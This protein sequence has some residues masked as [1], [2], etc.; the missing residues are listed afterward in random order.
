MLIN[1]SEL[2]RQFETENYT[3]SQ[4]NGLIL[5]GECPHTLGVKEKLM[6]SKQTHQNRARSLKRLL[7]ENFGLSAEEINIQLTN[8]AS[9]DQNNVKKKQRTG[10]RFLQG[11]KIASSA[12]E[13]SLHFVEEDRLRRRTIEDKFVADPSRTTPNVFVRT[14]QLQQEFTLL[15]MQL[16]V[17]SREI[18]NYHASAVEDF[19]RQL[20]ANRTAVYKNEYGITRRSRKQIAEYQSVILLHEESLQMQKQRIHNLWAEHVRNRD[21]HNDSLID[22][23][24]RSLQWGL[25]LRTELQFW[26]NWG[27]CIYR[28][29]NGECLI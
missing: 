20:V 5:G 1:Q 28:A 26:G 14:E 18:E 4:L 13:P 12:D 11:T 10:V 9:F 25:F 21:A 19:H 15:H 29:D 8:S 24:E 27:F 17:L 7:I 3:I 2:I 6:L 22:L 23:H 16:R